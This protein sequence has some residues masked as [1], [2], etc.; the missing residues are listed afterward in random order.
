MKK[1]FI[2]LIVAVI[3]VCIFFTSLANVSFAK[4]VNCPDKKADKL[5]NY[6]A[7]ATDNVNIAKSFNE[8]SNSLSIS[9]GSLSYNISKDSNQPITTTLESGE[10]IEMSLPEE[11]SLEKGVESKCASVMYIGSNNASFC[12]QI[13]E[14]PVCEDKTYSNRNSIIIENSKATHQ[15]TFN[16]NLPSGYI[17][18]AAAEYNE[19]QLEYYRNSKNKLLRSGLSENEFDNIISQFDINSK[20]VYVINEEN[21]IVE[22]IESP[23]AKD[24]NGNDIE[25]N[26]KIEDNKIIQ[27]V[28]FDENSSFPI[29][30]DPTAHPTNYKYF[31]LKK[32]SVKTLRDK[33]ATSTRATI[34]GYISSVALT[35]FSILSVGL[36]SVSFAN[37]LYAVEKHKLWTKVYDGFK[38]KRNMVKIRV[39]YTWNDLHRAYAPSRT[40]KVVS[41]YKK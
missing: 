32:A 9:E 28:D 30:A 3:T 27:N 26:Y 15:Y 31:S 38:G 5:A 33:Y 17:L 8:T 10:T 40:V 29:I 36:A 20:E 4:S 24:S 1:K 7:K 25:T 39:A 37:N 19:K 18:S 21:E 22:I 41:Y 23:W 12:T 35:K 11:L 13:L 2:N 6:V 14:E 34:L 16:F